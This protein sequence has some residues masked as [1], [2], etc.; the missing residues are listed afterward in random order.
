M[1][2]L[3]IQVLVRVGLF[4]VHHEFHG[5]IFLS[6]Q[7]CVQKKKK[8]KKN[9]SLVLPLKGKSNTPRR[10]YLFQMFSKILTFFDD[11]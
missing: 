8:K 9:I 10:V 1:L 4:T 3:K 5:T 7:K 2:R 11:L 6:N